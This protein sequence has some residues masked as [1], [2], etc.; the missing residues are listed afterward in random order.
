MYTPSAIPDDA[1]DGLKAWLADQ[2][3]QIANEL[4]A[5]QPRTVTLA[6]L[7]VEPQR[8]RN[9]MVAYA[10]GTLW[11]PGSGEGFYG[12]EGGAWVKL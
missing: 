1:P 5:P 11:D 12:Y 4:M 2:F 8:R 6:V 7:G 10:D 9:G 3:R